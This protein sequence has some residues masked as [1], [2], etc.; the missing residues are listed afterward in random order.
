MSEI[1][2]GRYLTSSSLCFIQL[3]SCI[4]GSKWGFDGGPYLQTISYEWV[5]YFRFF[6][7]G[8]WLRAE[9]FIRALFLCDSLFLASEKKNELSILSQDTK[10]TITISYSYSRLSAIAENSLNFYRLINLS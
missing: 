9:N 4:I 8:S 2:I 7:L 10:D 6:M 5:A 3:P 1:G